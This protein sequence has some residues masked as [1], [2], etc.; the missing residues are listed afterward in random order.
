MNTRYHY[1]LCSFILLTLAGRPTNAQ[2]FVFYS[3]LDD[4]NLHEPADNK[5]S[6]H[7]G[8]TPEHDPILPEGM[9]LDEALN[10]AAQPT[11]NDYPDVVSDNE[12]YS[13]ILFDQLEYRALEKGKNQFV[14]DAQGW[15]GYDFDKLW[16]K[17][18]G[19]TAFD[20]TN[21]G[22]TE[23]DLLYSRLI[24]PFWYAQAGVQYANEWSGGDYDDRYSAVVALQGLAPGMFEIDASFYLSDDADITATIE[25]EYDFRLTQRLVLQP[26]AE[27]SF[28][29]QDVPD[30][31]LGAGMTDAAFD[32]RLR[33][34]ITRKF[35]PYIGVGYSVL[36]GETANIA[37]STGGD[38]EQLF[39]TAGLRLA[40]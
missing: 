27:F 4:H 5:H 30:R 40:F 3:L 28:A 12:I 13:F 26:R 18:E 22:G 32:L 33:Y 21:A 31:G 16:F 19:E 7:F 35:A 34:E 2:D 14:W 8:Q 1:A 17:S 25:A 23:N 39:L 24:S 38:R 20:G 10:F 9:S 36:T 6:T 15:I 29:A 11:P 37:T